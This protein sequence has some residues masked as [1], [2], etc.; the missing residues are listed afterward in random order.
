MSWIYCLVYLLKGEL[1]WMTVKASNMVE[2]YNLIG[3]IKKEKKAELLQGLPDTFTKIYN[4][5]LSLGFKDKPNYGYLRQELL[6]LMKKN[7][8][9]LDYKYDW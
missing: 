5:A 6:A 9:E 8:Y 2:A 1:P 3:Q 7:G 4:Y